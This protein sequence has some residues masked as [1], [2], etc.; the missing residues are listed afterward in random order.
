MK[1]YIRCLL[2]A[3]IFGL[4]APM[5]ASA[6]TVSTDKTT[7]Y[8]VFQNNKA[9]MEY[10]NYT[11]ALKYAQQYANSHIEAIGTRTW[12]WDNF[13]RYQVYENGTPLIDGAF[14]S[15]DLAKQ[16]AKAG[17][18]RSVRDLQ[19][20]GWIW[21]NYPRY[22]LY[23]L[24]N[25]Q[26]NWEY[27]TLQE[28]TLEAKKW[29]MSQII[30]LQTNRWVWDNYT[31]AT[32]ASLRAG[33]VKYR[34]YQGT[35]S[36]DTWQFAYLEDAVNEAL[37]W[38]DTTIVNLSTE[39]VIF[40][41]VRKY[42]VYQDSNLL[43]TFVFYIDAIAYA[44]Q[45]SNSKVVWSEKTIW[46]NVPYYQIMYQDQV[47]ARFATIPLALKFANTQKDVTI[48]TLDQQEIWDNLRKLQMWAWTGKATTDT[49]VNQAVPTMGLDIISPTFFE[50]SDASGNMKDYASLDTI[51][52][53]KQLGF[54]IHPLVHNQFN[55]SLT[56]AFLKSP[57]ARQKF[58]QLLVDRV[59]ELGL[60][61][62]NI[63]FESLAG[64][65]RS[66]FTAFIEQLTTYAHQKNI[67]VSLDLPRGN[68]LWN[69]STAFE[70]EKLGQLVDYIH[71]MAYDENWS[72]SKKPG[73]VSTLPWTETGILDFLSYGIPRS[74]IVL[75]VPF[76][77]REWKLDS[78]GVL[79]SNRAISMKEVKN[80][81]Q[82]KSVSK[83]WD[84]TALQAKYTYV[85]N[86][87]TYVFWLEDDSTVQSRM[88][89]AKKYELAG[90]A[91]WRLGYDYPELW[92][93]ILQN[94]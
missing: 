62:V 58:I 46:T 22:R 74:K 65:N 71:I 83:E 88:E 27:S 45:W 21:H 52:R 55:S 50:L 72:G 48:V 11:S 79:Q 87:Y 42:Q 53:L 81:I 51:N 18:Y 4:V 24:E 73:S 85:E 69:H 29:A 25:T 10:A 6:L 80:L 63:D 8:R 44:K 26:S 86:G 28:A 1:F 12:L 14:A 15:L 75:G 7:K 2:I 68:M 57:D 43:Q 17:T 78:S 90:I 60:P 93:T 35:T 40:E 77:V 82:N 13:P 61:G 3:I 23:Q 94:K 56:S 32:K 54:S 64:S 91:A 33:E 38:A 76:Y 37:K 59:S 30:D 31:P 19:S 66:L 67:V 9:L 34:I 89:L 41:N 49:I 92:Q 47:L 84:P 16:R 70:H 20:S 39:Q 36:L 5:Y